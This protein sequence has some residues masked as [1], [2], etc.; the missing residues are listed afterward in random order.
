[1]TNSSNGQESNNNN[2]TTQTDNQTSVVDDLGYEHPVEG[3]GEKSS[4]ENPTPEGDKKPEES[5]DGEGTK[6][7]EAKSGYE[8]SEEGDKESEGEGAKTGYGEGEEPKE[9]ESKEED[10]KP[11]ED[12]NKSDEEKRKVEIETAIKDFPE[13]INKDKLSKFALENGFTKEQIEAYKNLVVEENAQA[14]KNSQAQVLNT[15]K[16]WKDELMSDKEFGGE[17]FDN[18]VHK[19][20]QVINKFMPNTKKIL[21]ERGNMLPP[22]T[23]RDLLGIHKLLNPTDKL[24][25]GE[26]GQVQTKEKSFLEEM[27]E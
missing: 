2:P 12:E 7:P 27:Y 13:N 26:P 20:E 17:N 9:P 15:R 14:E 8:S 18:N 1:M 22:S 6:E 10:K 25:T 5:K 24:V 16:A 4:E 3:E 23:M 19:V 21:T 11:E